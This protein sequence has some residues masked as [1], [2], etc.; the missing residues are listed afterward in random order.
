MIRVGL[1]T[2]GSATMSDSET[3]EIGITNRAY[4]EDVVEFG[5]RV[6]GEQLRAH[7]KVN[8]LT[9][10]GDVHIQKSGAAVD[11]VTGETYWN[12]GAYARVL[13]YE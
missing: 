6:M 12:V 2:V 9:L 11:F 7:I 8:N 10:V 5:M 4:S 1:S 13:S 3:V